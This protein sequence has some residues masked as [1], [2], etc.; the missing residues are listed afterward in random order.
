VESLSRWPELGNP[1]ALARLLEA[2]AHLAAATG[3]HVEAVRLAGAAERLRESAGR[4]ASAAERVAMERWLSP[5]CAALGDA[6]AAGVWQEGRAVP[7][8]QALQVA[9]ASL[10]EDGPLDPTTPAAPRG[11]R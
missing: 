8:E 11:Q 4:P 1:A 3:R 6:A 9:S 2:S 5:A 10:T 7:P